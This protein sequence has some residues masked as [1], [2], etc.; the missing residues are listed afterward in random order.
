[1][2]VEHYENFPVASL[3]CPPRL[4]PAVT[5]IYWFA[6]TADDIAD[7]GSATPE[8]RRAR[9]K[10]F[11]VALEAAAHGKVD[12]GGRWK[13]VFEPLS[14]A[15]LGERLPLRLLNDLL[16]AFE[17]DVGNPLYPDREA[18]LGYCRCSANPIGRLLLHLYDIDDESLQ[19]QSDQI[20]SALQLINFWQDLSVDLCRGR[21]YVP[22]EDARTLGLHCASL[23]DGPVARRL[24]ADLCAW[25]RSLMLHGAPLVHS[26]PGRVGWE[27][28]LVV[29]GG[30][31]VLEKIARMDY[32][33]LVR[34]PTLRVWDVPVLL[35]RAST[36]RPHDGE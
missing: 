8:E 19:C 9:L 12:A 7:E 30:L 25:A 6:R 3:L 16:D 32:A 10:E 21:C 22:L 28:R 18:L 23:Q 24:V 14:N 15:I 27:L 4:R 33:T 26:L 5:A 20:C 1:M 13:H 34:R 35:A 36:M 11:R 17:R 31:R 2:N 29:Q